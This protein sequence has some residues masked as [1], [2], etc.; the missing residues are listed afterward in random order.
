MFVNVTRQDGTVIVVNSEHVESIG[1]CEPA[2]KQYGAKSTIH[3]SSGKF[4]NVRTTIEETEKLFKK[5]KE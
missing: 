3:Y 4:V 1:P 2:A 5:T